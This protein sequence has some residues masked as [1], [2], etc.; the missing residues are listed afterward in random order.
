MSAGGLVTVIGQFLHPPIGL[1]SLELAADPHVDNAVY[2]R[3]RGPIL[4]DAFG[5]NVQVYDWPAG[6]GHI[7][8]AGL[9]EFDRT[10]IKINVLHDLFDSSQLWTD[11]LETSRYT[12]TMMFAESFPRSV[13]VWTAPGVTARVSWLLLL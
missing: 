1:C 3:V 6:Y 2:Q 4:V 7:D 8:T 10:V 11:N 13:D 12:V 9:V 5:I